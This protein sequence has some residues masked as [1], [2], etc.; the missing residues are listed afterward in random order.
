MGPCCH[1]MTVCMP[2]WLALKASSLRHRQKAQLIVAGPCHEVPPR[3]SSSSPLLSSCHTTPI[4]S[5]SWESLRVRRFPPCL[6]ASPLIISQVRISFVKI[7]APCV[8]AYCSLDVDV[9]DFLMFLTS[10]YNQK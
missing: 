2:S 4:D 5:A 9:E 8:H 1:L 6:P 10:H 7:C 3:G